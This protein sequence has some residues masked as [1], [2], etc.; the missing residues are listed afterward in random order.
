MRWPLARPLKTVACA[1]M[2]P[3]ACRMHSLPAGRGAAHAA[4]AA[5]CK[6]RQGVRRPPDG[7]RPAG[8]APQAGD[9][10]A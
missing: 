2:S 9:R 10:T 7:I 4:V 3:S 1:A 6:G 5:G 8:A